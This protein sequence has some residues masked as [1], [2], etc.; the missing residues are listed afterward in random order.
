[1]DQ[2]HPS[3]PGRRYNPDD[4][5]NPYMQ[6]R[7]RF[8]QCV[9]LGFSLACGF[10]FRF[11][12][13]DT[14]GGLFDI[15]IGVHGSTLSTDV[16][17]G[18][19][20]GTCARIAVAALTDVAVTPRIFHD[21]NVL[22]FYRGGPDGRYILSGKAEDLNMRAVQSVRSSLRPIEDVIPNDAPYRDYRDRIGGM[23]PDRARRNF[24]RPVGSLSVVLL[25][26][27]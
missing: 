23:M 17:G 7:P 19:L 12:L 21:R 16:V 18:K 10:Q 6:Y 27:D 24:A 25:T 11:Q 3:D 15:A 13:D 14:T 22:P 20:S 8:G 1:M 4:G 2:G 5:I 26:A 9:A